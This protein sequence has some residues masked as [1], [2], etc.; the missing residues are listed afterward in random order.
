MNV[1]KLNWGNGLKCWKWEALFGSNLVCRYGGWGR[2][3]GEEEEG[4][5]AGVWVLW[6]DSDTA[7]RPGAVCV[8]WHLPYSSNPVFLQL[9][10]YYTSPF[11]F[12]LPSI[13]PS[14]L[15]AAKTVLSSWLLFSCTLSFYESLLIFYSFLHP[16]LFLCF[17][18]LCSLCTGIHVTNLSP[19]K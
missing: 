6:K 4:V 9:A 2:E 14:L 12:S 11:P 15:K 17:S 19:K 3:E 13:H 5:V 16:A 7:M 10:S 18:V 1:L 8:G